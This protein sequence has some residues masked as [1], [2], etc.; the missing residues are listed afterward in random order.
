VTTFGESLFE[1]DPE[2]ASTSTQV[3]DLIIFCHIGAPQRAVLVQFLVALSTT[4]PDTL[5]LYGIVHLALQN[6]QQTK[7]TTGPACSLLVQVLYQGHGTS[8][9]CIFGACYLVH[10]LASST[11]LR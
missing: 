2:T 1:T 4:V 9:A 3:M 8:T 7:A 10:S 6:S 5:A 11:L